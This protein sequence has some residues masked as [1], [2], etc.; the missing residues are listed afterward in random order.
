MFKWFKIDKFNLYLE[1]CKHRHQFTLQMSKLA[2]AIVR[3]L[4]NW[5]SPF[6]LIRNFS[7][8]PTAKEHS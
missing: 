7:P 2:G 4:Q 8:I 3:Y 6:F 1:A 5:I